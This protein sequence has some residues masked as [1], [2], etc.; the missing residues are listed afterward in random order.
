[1]TAAREKSHPFLSLAAL[2]TLLWL[3]AAA[4]H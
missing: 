2:Y 4:C 1:M 3:V